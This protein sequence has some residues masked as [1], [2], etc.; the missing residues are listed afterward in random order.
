VKVDRP[1]QP[2]KMLV[3]MSQ[4]VF[5]D[6]YVSQPEKVMVDIG[7]GYYLEKDT[8]KAADFMSSKVEGIQKSAAQV[9]QLLQKKQ[10]VLDEATQRLMKLQK[11]M[12]G[13]Q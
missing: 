2:L 3:P 4:A 11:E 13:A 1:P 10:S 8:G 6:A 12:E 9:S 5:V 7:T